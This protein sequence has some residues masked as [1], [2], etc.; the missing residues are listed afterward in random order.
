MEWRSRLA[1]AAMWGMVIVVGIPLTLTY[2][3]SEWLWQKFMEHEWWFEK[4][5]ND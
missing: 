1:T 4:Y 5:S 3:G 2:R